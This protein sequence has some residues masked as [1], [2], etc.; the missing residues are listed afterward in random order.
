MATTD[1]GRECLCPLSDFFAELS[2]K[3]SLELICVIGH[4]E[5]ARFTTIEEHFPS[6]STSTISNRLGNLAELGFVTREQYDEIP[7][8]VEYSLTES[9]D[10]LCERL[11]PV[12]EWIEGLDGELGVDRPQ[13]R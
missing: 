6:A 13:T 3:Y 4:H 10:E 11:L 8:R 12:L 9:G 2:R 5:P 1:P 7:P